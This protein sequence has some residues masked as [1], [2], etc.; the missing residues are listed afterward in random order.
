MGPSQVGPPQQ[1]S[2]GWGRLGGACLCQGLR[3]E[4]GSP[5]YQ[6]PLARCLDRL[7]AAESGLE[8]RCSLLAPIA[9]WSW[10]PPRG[11]WGARREAQLS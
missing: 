5:H 3:A 7:R 4:K 6:S 2:G 10:A 9:W 1:V 11:L 8:G